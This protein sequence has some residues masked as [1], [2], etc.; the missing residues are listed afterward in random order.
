MGELKAAFSTGLEVLQCCR[1]LMSSDRAPVT[2]RRLVAEHPLLH[3][4]PP[5]SRSKDALNWGLSVAH[6]HACP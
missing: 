1:T 5:P 2:R 3:H 6:K 4:P